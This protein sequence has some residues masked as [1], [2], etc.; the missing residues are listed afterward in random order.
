MFDACPLICSP[1]TF[2]REFATLAAPLKARLGI[3][4]RQRDLPHAMVLW[5]LI[6]RFRQKARQRLQQPAAAYHRRCAVQL[7]LQ[8]NPL[9]K[10]WACMV[11]F[12][13]MPTSFAQTTWSEGMPCERT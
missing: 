1:V 2:V 9:M 5:S 11:L 10:I 13:N 12:L 7:R 3:A 6:R 4:L 8:V